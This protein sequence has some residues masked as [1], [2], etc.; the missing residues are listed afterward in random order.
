[1][2]KQMK[3]A[4]ASYARSFIVAVCGLALAGES[5]PKVLAI[6]ALAGI[7]GPAIRA[8]NPNDEAFGVVADKADEEIRTLIEKDKA[9]K[10][11]VKKK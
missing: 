8:M 11:A 2:S 5:D 3:A 1:M 4:L 7:V 9:K 10:K 6:S